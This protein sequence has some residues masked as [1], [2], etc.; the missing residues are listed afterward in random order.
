MNIKASYSKGK[1]NAHNQEG[2]CYDHDL[3]QTVA[4]KPVN[5][6]E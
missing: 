1:I 6:L 3:K 4:G 2:D 5:V